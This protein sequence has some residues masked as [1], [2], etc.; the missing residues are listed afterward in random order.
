MA[1]GYCTRCLATVTVRGGS[2]LLGHPVDLSTVST[3]R[4]RHARD[5]RD[6]QPTIPP[7]PVASTPAPVAPVRTQPLPAGSR[8]VATG[9]VL[10]G[11][12]ALVDRLWAETEEHSL[13]D[14][15]WA[16][17]GEDL[18]RLD[19]RARWHRLLILPVLALLVAGGWYGYGYLVEQRRADATVEFA[20]AIQDLTTISETVGSSTAAVF[21]ADSDRS[22][23]VT[24]LGDFEAA[25]RRLLVAAGG[26]DGV[27]FRAERARA[28]ELAGAASS[29]EDAVAAV[30]AY[31]ALLESALRPP[32]LPL[33]ADSTE[34]GDL[35][36]EL[37]AWLGMVDEAL[38]QAPEHDLVSGHRALLVELRP[39]LDD[40]VA[41]YLAG[42]RQGDRGEAAAAIS[43]MEQV[44]RDLRDEL[45]AV[46]LE[47]EA[48]T[49]VALDELRSGLEGLSAPR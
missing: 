3:R 1:H 38:A 37:A 4:G 6:E 21:T 22:A 17:T 26:L 40:L 39:E 32:V 9:S 44:F 23:L 42:I 5:G 10:E 15:G 43:R 13:S 19:K 47:A 34:A 25:A 20:A 36:A 2:C 30:D 18:R 35:A 31:R 8:Q 46:T 12:H 45:A 11:S 48:W 28:S 16:P 27:E 14:L 33:R 24:D 29:I 41:R 7:P 49:A